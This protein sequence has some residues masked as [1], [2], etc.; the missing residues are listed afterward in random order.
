MGGHQSKLTLATYN[1]CTLR[2]DSHLAQ[3]EVEL[4]KIRWLVLELCEVRREREDTITLESG[5]SQYLRERDQQSPVDVGF[6]VNNTLADNVVEI[7]SVSNR[8][9][10]LIV[11]LTQV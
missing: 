10:Y 9:A 8:V 7:S 2:L 6:L 1:G 5:H 11:K 4:G 3:L